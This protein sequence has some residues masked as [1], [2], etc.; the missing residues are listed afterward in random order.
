M[1]IFASN[2]I[3]NLL[4]QAFAISA[5]QVRKTMS[6]SWGDGTCLKPQTG[7]MEV[8]RKKTYLFSYQK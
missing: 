5:L 2:N 4:K 1:I 7:E 6:R 3:N 8:E